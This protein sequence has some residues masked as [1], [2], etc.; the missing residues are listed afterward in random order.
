MF[1]FSDSKLM[2]SRSF[3]L[4]PS[5]DGFIKWR[6]MIRK[7]QIPPPQINE[8]RNEGNRMHFR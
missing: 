5:F 4:G 8:Y 2:I 3:F 7:L 1:D 6:K